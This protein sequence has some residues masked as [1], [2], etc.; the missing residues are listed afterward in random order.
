MT[1]REPPES[2]WQGKLS[3][4]SPP[5]RRAEALAKPRVQRRSHPAAET[6]EHLEDVGKLVLFQIEIKTIWEDPKPQS[7]ISDISVFLSFSHNRK[8]VDFDYG[9]KSID[10]N[11]KRVLVF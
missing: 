11:I 7:C 9:M 4:P 2:G 5:G 1:G 8:K 10:R 6:G 3:R